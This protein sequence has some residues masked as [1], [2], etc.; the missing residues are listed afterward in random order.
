MITLKRSTHNL[1]QRRLLTGAAYARA[2]APSRQLTDTLNN[3]F[4]HQPELS[5]P[6]S[7][8]TNR[9]KGHGAPAL[10]PSASAKDAM[11]R[12][13]DCLSLFVPFFVPS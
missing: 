9:L 1:A 4:N 7:Q 11:R 5:L 3:S 13:K 2:D 10:T 12:T 6:A 8:L